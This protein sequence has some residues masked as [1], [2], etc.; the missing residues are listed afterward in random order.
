MICMSQIMDSPFRYVSFPGE[1]AF[2][3]QLSPP[4]RPQVPALPADVPR[5]EVAPD[6][7]LRRPRGKLVLAGVAAHGAP[8][9]AAAAHSSVPGHAPAA[10]STAAAASSA[11]AACRAAA[12][13][14]CDCRRHADPVQRGT[15]C[16]REDGQHATAAC[17][18][19]RDG[20]GALVGGLDLELSAAAQRQSAQAV[21]QQQQPEQGEL[22]GVFLQRERGQGRL[23]VRPLQHRRRQQSRV[24]TGEAGMPL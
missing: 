22:R 21:P 16:G 15:A 11:A 6:P 17:Q 14:R 8:A 1:R 23:H 3:Y 9:A 2:Q 20:G 12:G 5:H 4:D 7:L 10:S 13:C 24:Q 19:G 18:E